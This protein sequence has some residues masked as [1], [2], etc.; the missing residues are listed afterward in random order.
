MPT[1]TPSE[2]E[3]YRYLTLK[4]KQADASQQQPKASNQAEQP[5]Q[6][7][8]IG[9]VVD[10]AFSPIAKTLTGTSLSDRMMN[11]IGMQNVVNSFDLYGNNPVANAATIASNTLT[12]TLADMAESFTA[13]AA[14][15]GGLAS[16][17]PAVQQAGRAIASS[18][19]SQAVVNDAT[20]NRSLKNIF[21]YDSALKQAEKTKVALDSLRKNL[22][23]AKE[24]ALSNTGHIPVE[25][26]FSGNVSSK[27]VN[28]I[29]NPIYEVEFPP[30]GV[31]VENIRH[32]DHIKMSMNDIVTAKDFVEAGNMEKR[33]IMQFAG[34][35]RDDMVR[36]AND[37]GKPEL[38]NALKGY[39]DF[40]ERYGKIND[41][42]VDKYGDA[43]ANKLKATF[44]WNAEPA[45]KQAWKD[46]SKSSPEV[47]QVMNSMKRREL[48]KDL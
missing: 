12:G 8:T 33:Q 21:R 1:P 39:H 38:G 35:L 34:R 46:V 19:A 6:Q 29:K 2:E 31:V 32:L 3:R 11:K 36:A 10:V 16:K 9:K 30:E 7:S 26:T 25:V 27:V 37:A 42:L 20:K 23:Q 47:K 5:N 43:M 4:K 14:I 24:I 48:L 13:P 44:K 17:I 22:G 28:A 45:I 40:M 18:Q 15:V 41:H